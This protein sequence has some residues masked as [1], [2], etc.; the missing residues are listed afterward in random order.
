MRLPASWGCARSTPP[1]V[2]VGAYVEDWTNGAGAAV[3][4]EV[5]GA[6]AG[7]DTAISAMAVRGRLVVV[8]IHSTPPPVDLF[9]VFW[10]ELTLI[11]ARVYQRSDFEEAVSLLASGEVLVEPLITAVEPLAGVADAFATLEAGRAMKVL[12][13]CGAGAAE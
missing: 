1:R 6:V 8:A 4:F 9:R 3:G 2:D 11:G 13:D 12:I 5:S 10:R 7:L